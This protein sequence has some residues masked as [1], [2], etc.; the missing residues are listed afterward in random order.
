MRILIAID[1]SEHSDR[2]VRL[3]AAMSWPEGAVFRIVSVID[4]PVVGF[5]VAPDD[6]IRAEMKRRLDG[7]VA[8][9]AERLPGDTVEREVLRGRAASKILEDAVVHGADLI[10]VG[11]RGQSAVAALLLG[12]VA[13]EV[14][15]KAA[16]PVLVARSYALGPIVLGDDGSRHARAARELLATWPSLRPWPVRVV[17]AAHVTAPLASGVA[18]TMRRAAASAHADEVSTALA[19]HSAIAEE[20]VAYLEA[21]GISATASA[22][23]GDPARAILA[24]AAET[25]ARLIVV[26]SRGRGGIAALL[27]SVARTVVLGAPCSVLVVH[28][29]PASSSGA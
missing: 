3:V 16:V 2:A 26:G 7:A 11:H 21:R 24:A 19:A 1:G 5:D 18:P 10:V 4:D 20:T 28:G 9:A 17:S 13:T 23:T 15:E 8:A 29:E 22:S 27:G 14:V 25:R 6:L 12:S